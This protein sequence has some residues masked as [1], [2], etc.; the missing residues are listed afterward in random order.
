MAA[1]F[2][3]LEGYVTIPAA[4]TI[5][6]NDGGGAVAVTVP[7]ATYKLTGAAGLLAALQTALNAAALVNS[8]YVT[9]ISDDS[10]TAATGKVTLSAGGAFTVTTMSALLATAL[11]L[12]SVTEWNSSAASHTSSLSSPYVFLPGCRRDPSLGPDGS[13]GLLVVS[14][15][16]TI[17][18]GGQMA[19]LVTGRRYRDTLGFS[20]LRG[21]RVHK[22]L[23]ADD[24]TTLESFY[25]LVVGNGLR[26]DYHA[27]RSVDA[28]FVSYRSPSVGEFPARAVV[29]A[30]TS[31]AASLWAWTVDVVLYVA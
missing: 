21:D 8:D 16:S 27:D 31:G 5:T 1:D 29:P 17:A 7:A 2:P 20:N 18:D 3:K 9:S 15:S 12:A 19:V 25:E 4:T 13:N 26:F 30:W 10:D 6:V 23:C 11:G 28:T 14:G 24:N 22:H